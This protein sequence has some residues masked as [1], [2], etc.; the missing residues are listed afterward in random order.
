M[1]V[2]R[3]RTLTGKKRPQ[4]KFNPASQIRSEV[5]SVVSRDGES[6]VVWRRKRR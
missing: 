4:S 2:G 1:Y 6:G 3:M 5:K